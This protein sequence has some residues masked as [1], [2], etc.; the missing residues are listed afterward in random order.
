LWLSATRSKYI[1][2]LIFV[3]TFM[4]IVVF[5]SHFHPLLRWARRALIAAGLLILLF[6]AAWL[7]L[8]RWLQGSGA[9]LV[10][11]ALGRELSVAEVSFQPWRLALQL[12][13]VRVAAAAGQDPAKALLTLERVEAVFSWRSVWY[14]APVLESLRLV[15]PVL[16]LSRVSAGH[17]DIDD[18]L[19]RWAKPSPTGADLP[20]SPVALA[21]YNIELIDGEV[22]LDDQPQGRLH[23]LTALRLDLPFI[24]TLNADIAVHVEPKLAGALNGVAFD[25]RAQWL[26]FAEQGEASLMLQ[27][28]GLDLLPYRAY[29]PHALPLRVQRGVVDADLALT[30][31]QAKGKEPQLSLRGQVHLRDFALQTP[32][33]A[34]WLSWRDL[35]VPINNAQPLLRNIELGGVTWWAP[36][37]ALSR[38]AAGQLWL[39]AVA[40]EAPR[41]VSREGPEPANPPKP[42]KPPE[43]PA[44]RLS[45]DRFELKDASV[46]WRDAAEGR[47]S[48]LR[49]DG[50]TAQ[51][52]AVTWP[53][54]PLSKSQKAAA[55]SFGMRLLPA[56]A[57][58]KVETSR[59][60]GAGTLAAEQLALKWRWQGLALEWLAPY[61]QAQVPVPVE[62]RGQLSGRGELALDYPLAADAAARVKLDLRE[63]ALQDL[64]VSALNAAAPNILRVGTLSLD[65]LTLD[66]AAQQLVAGEL[67]LNQAV[68]ELAREAKGAWNFQSLLPVTAAGAPTP[69]PAAAQTPADINVKPW[70]LQ[71]AGLLIDA[72]SLQWRDADAGLALSA[73]K[74]RLRVQDLAWPAGAKA[75][76]I[77]LGMKLAALPD[78]PSSGSNRSVPAPQG[79]VQWQ[80][81]VSLAPLSASGSLKLDRLP[82]QWLD[83]LLDPTWGVHLQ[84]AELG[85]RSEFAAKQLAEGWRTQLSGELVLADLRLQQ[86]RQIDTRRVTGE[87]LLSWQALKLGGLN[88]VM[89]P[90]ATPQ[91]TVAVARLDDFYA[92][93]IVNEGGRLNLRELGPG[94]PP[95]RAAGAAAASVAAPALNVTIQQTQLSQGRIDFSDRFIRP[96]YSAQLT[97]LTGSLGAFSSGSSG[98]AALELRGRVAGTG[99]LEIQGQVNPGAAPLTL[100]ITA[101]AS[102]IELAPLSPYAAKY[103]GYAI[104]QGKFSS[105][106]HYKIAPTGNLEASNQI[107]LNQLTFGERVDSPQATQLPVLLAV[108]LL[109][110]RNGVIDLN[111]PI[112]GSINDP[113]FSV[114]GLLVRVLGNLLGRAL[115]A[116]FSLFSSAEPGSGSADMSQATFAPG[117]VVL[118]EPEQLDKV[119][120]LL[121]D[122]PGLKLTLTGWA[123][124][125]TERLALQQLALDAELMAV[126][127]RELLR[128]PGSAAAAA[129][130]MAD[131]PGQFSESERARLLKE[132]YQASKLPDKPRNVL[133]FAKGIAPTEMRALLLASFPVPDERLRQLAL[134]R[135]VVVRDGLI[136]K[137]VPTHRINLAAPDLTS[138]AADAADSPAASWVPHV[139]LKLAAE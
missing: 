43:T 127:Q 77:Q 138:S 7:A 57:R 79:D 8:P 24:S 117:S 54:S 55:F 99:V 31:S 17:Y 39:P 129:K 45:W 136:A 19:A 135:G 15:K 1:P 56:T 87:D 61:L 120:R 25:S 42:T 46:D 132:V 70:A 10:S 134:Q 107:T 58:G 52:G 35:Q 60:E 81:Q 67:V 63:L 75:L 64:R 34:P 33:G 68:A 23:Q 88:W 92:R 29:F 93:L 53:L 84:Q 108:A 114:G 128:W 71:L 48:A 118:L 41:E 126:R 95:A 26:P 21:L 89:N 105:K 40:A 38:D 76:P 113:E 47:Q 13:G 90:G 94:E 106:V 4:P 119:A 72:S 102:D 137:G 86:A 111:L 18:L 78:Q 124:A 59:I 6:L 115:T 69:T 96:N 91:L 98:M 121:Q 66:L 62:V 122:R 28:T 80:G 16:H 30:F 32:A 103:A 74:I 130:A 101:A 85:L 11:Q 12:Q 44:W 27:W 49:L 109:K 37:L 65:R 22:R 20:S 3:T 139:A 110:D 5:S 116:P 83:V 125:A 36:E 9:A 97:D 133:G 14:R 112:S 51:V 50:I 100:D 82:L 2:P 131:G 73:E 123:D 104:E